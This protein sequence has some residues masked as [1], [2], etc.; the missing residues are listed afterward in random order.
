M[1]EGSKVMVFTRNYTTRNYT[2]GILHGVP[3][4]TALLHYT[5]KKEAGKGLKA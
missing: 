3:L 4:P 1:I 2:L 5:K